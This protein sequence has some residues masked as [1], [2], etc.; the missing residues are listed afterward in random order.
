MFYSAILHN[1]QTVICIFSAFVQ[2]H[3]TSS[4][5]LQSREL[6]ELKIKTGVLR[7]Y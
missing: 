7:A 6:E 4:T 1:L 5:H 2:F 3:F